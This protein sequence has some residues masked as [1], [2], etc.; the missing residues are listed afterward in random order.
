INRRYGSSVDP[1]IFG[2][3]KSAV[4][5]QDF[6]EQTQPI[7]FVV[8]HLLEHVGKIKI[9]VVSGGSRKTV[10]KTLT[11]LGVL[12]VIDLMVCAGETERGKPYPD[13]FLKAAELL[14][15]DPRRCLVFEDGN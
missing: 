8:Q 3:E 10:T 13:P 11:V 1:V 9:A 4:Y 2:R 12:E 6:I 7:G 15:V 14:D 5:M